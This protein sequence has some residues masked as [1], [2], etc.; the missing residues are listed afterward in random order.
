MQHDETEMQTLPSEALVFIINIFRWAL[1]GPG[2]IHVNNTY[3][4]HWKVTSCLIFG[5]SA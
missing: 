1:L 4:F 5:K 3:C 2:I